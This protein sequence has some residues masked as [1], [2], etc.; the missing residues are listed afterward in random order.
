MSLPQ[1]SFLPLSH[2]SDYGFGATADAFKE[3][4]DDLSAAQVSGPRLN[5]HLATAYLYRHA[6]ELYLKSMIVV[7][8]RRLRI[9]F[10]SYSADGEPCVVVEGQTKPFHRVHSVAKLFAYFHDLVNSQSDALETFCRTDWTAFP[11][12]VRD[13][14][15]L[16]ESTDPKSTFFRYPDPQNRAGDHSKSSFQA[17]TPQDIVASANLADKPIK[18][19][20]LVDESDSIVESYRFS[21]DVLPELQAAL[22][23]L[24]DLLEAAHYGMRIELADG[25]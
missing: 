25:L 7:L 5:G 20:V 14:I 1:Y 17:S 6:I 22:R 2:H 15:K 23:S 18:A 21:A 11:G 10:G 8:H 9:P 3:A 19:V 24:S 16:I 12:E 13:W 4:A